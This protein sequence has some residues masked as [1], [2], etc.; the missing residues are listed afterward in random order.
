MSNPI[1]KIR[2]ILRDY[3]FHLRNFRRNVK[4]LILS[5]L[6]FST[7]IGVFGVFFNVYLKKGGF[8]EDFI[9]GLSSIGTFTTVLIAIPAGIYASRVG[10]RKALL[11]ALPLLIVS[12][13]LS[14]ITLIPAVLIILSI[15]TGIGN[16][17]FNAAFNPCLTSNS[18]PE[19]RHY[20]FSLS[21][22]LMNFSGVAG[23]LLGGFVPD[24]LSDCFGL[25][26]FH[27]LRITLFSAAILAFSGFLP[28][29][30]LD[31]G[32][33]CEG[34]KLPRWGLDFSD[35][36]SI[37]VFSRFVI[38]NLIIG[39]GAGFTVP[40][41][42]IYF[43]SEF[44]LKP[45]IIGYIFSGAAAITGVAVLI[46]PLLVRRFG[47]LYAM[48]I[49]QAV[50]LPFI[51]VLAHSRVVWLSVAAFWIRGALMN[52]SNPVMNQIVME[53]SPEERRPVI[54]NLMSLSWNLAWA[55]SVAISGFMIKSRGYMLPFYITFVVYV[56]YVLTLYLFFRKDRALAT[57]EGL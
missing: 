22:G 11:Y 8:Q 46:S 37:R 17:I 20:V 32:V 34:P 42:S 9:G 43:S 50:S 36:K 52:A 38:L 14:S 41:L 28:L 24:L 6:L 55:C 40:F 53:K 15:L 5:H 49:P 30:K 12:Y 21:L 25:S 33:R 48:I 45:T 27:A 57:P 1:T 3:S 10:P 31:E 39:F 51:L 35:K 54:Q 23:S 7:A 56:A 16:M 19:N 29:L 47:K 18:L 44:G 26:E 4:L 13:A 2:T